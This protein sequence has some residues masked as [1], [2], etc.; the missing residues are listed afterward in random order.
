MCTHTPYT[1]SHML[2][3]T[4]A[5]PH[6]GRH[7]Y[8]HAH[9]HGGTVIHTHTHSVHTCAHV[10]SIT[11]THMHAQTQSHHAP[12]FLLCFLASAVVFDPGPV[13]GSLQGLVLSPSACPQ[14][15]LG[16]FMYVPWGKRRTSGFGPRES[17]LYVLLMVLTGWLVVRR[18]CCHKSGEVLVCA[19]C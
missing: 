16:P 1:E 18:E 9:V 2:K 15:R 11:H 10:H 7:I 8:L 12:S 5:H 17:S 4:H 14:D 19:I 3:Y 6:L 13:V